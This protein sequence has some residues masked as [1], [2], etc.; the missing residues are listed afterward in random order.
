MMPRSLSCPLSP[1]VL[2]FAEPVRSASPLRA[3]PRVF[4]R[5]PALRGTL[6][7]SYAVSANADN[8]EL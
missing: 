6:D 2:K 3:P 7:G 4:K 8:T 5:S 1:L